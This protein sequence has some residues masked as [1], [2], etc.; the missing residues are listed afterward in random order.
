[1]LNRLASFLARPFVPWLFFAGVLAVNRFWLSP[2]VGATYGAIPGNTTFVFVRVSSFFILS[3]L[4]ARLAGFQ[5]FRTISAL[6]L[7]VALEHLGFNLMGI[8]SGYRANPSEYPEGLSGPLF[9]LTVSYMMGLPFILLIGFLGHALG[10][11][12][13]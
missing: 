13:N 3:V 8:L 12:K 1:M 2:A 10:Q 11:R 7:L 6:A 5:R 9:G 4:L